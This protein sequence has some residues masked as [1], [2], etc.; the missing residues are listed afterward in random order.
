[1]IQRWKF[2]FLCWFFDRPDALKRRVEV[3]DALNTH[4]KNKTSPT[5][6]ECRELALKLGVP[7]WFKP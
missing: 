6:E 7:R 2:R 3:E 1:M 5:P 4:Y